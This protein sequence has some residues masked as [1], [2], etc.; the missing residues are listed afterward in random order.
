MSIRPFVDS[1]GSASKETLVPE[2][3]LAGD[4]RG[5]SHNKTMRY[6]LK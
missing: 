3:S 5:K 2:R 6:I 1:H 4:C